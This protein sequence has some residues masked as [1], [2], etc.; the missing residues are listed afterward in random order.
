MPW[1]VISFDGDEILG[2]FR[3]ERTARRYK[4]RLCKDAGAEIATIQY[5]AGLYRSRAS[6][7]DR[8]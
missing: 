2:E 7:P 1:L 8:R 3:T 5:A 4:I 6:M